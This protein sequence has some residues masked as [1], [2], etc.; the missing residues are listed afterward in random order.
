[1]AS[2]TKR[3]TRVFYDTRTDGVYRYPL[4]GQNRRDDCSV[5]AT[6]VTVSQGNQY[7]LL[8]RSDRDIGGNFETRD[9]M[10]SENGSNIARLNS[11]VIGGRKSFD[12]IA[13]NP[14]PNKW[15]MAYNGPLLATSKNSFPVIDTPSNT[16]L[17]AWGT[18]AISRTIPTSSDASLAQFLGE[19]KEGLPS[20]IGS[21][22]WK[23]K[24]KDFR[25]TGSEY[26]NVQFGWKPLISD[27]R[28]FATAVA[29]AD[30]ILAQLERDSGKN[31]RRRYTFPSEKSVTSS[32]AFPHYPNEGNLTIYLTDP[33]SL[34]TTTHRKVDKW[35]SGCYTYYLSDKTRDRVAATAQKARLL[36]GLELTPE[37]LWELAPWSWLVDYFANVGDVMSNISRFS[38]DGLVLRHGYIMYRETVRKEY[39]WTGNVS[40]GNKM[41]PVTLTQTFETT[42]KVRR[43]ATPYGFG[44]NLGS[45]S[46]SQWAILA[47]LG[48]SRAPKSL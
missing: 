47:A 3:R 9:Y 25:E 20:L 48:I 7:Q 10:Y 28:K 11:T 12:L 45:L 24:F 8:G 6:Q 30:S 16:A 5:R 44:F 39:T 35:F 40:I 15:G 4:A 23:T 32:V 38:N 21:S 33:G 13:G 46:D 43:K 29:N 34:S 14:V 26:L 41:T 22:L 18:T 1:M 36:L 37:L 2:T 27:V 19:L 31:V 42:L 17:D